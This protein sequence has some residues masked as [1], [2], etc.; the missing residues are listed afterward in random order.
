V[1]VIPSPYRLY[2]QEKLLGLAN[3]ECNILLS[4]S[5]HHLML[6][7]SLEELEGLMDLINQASNILQI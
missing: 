3:K 6:A 1:K 4:P 7:F 5:I 2:R